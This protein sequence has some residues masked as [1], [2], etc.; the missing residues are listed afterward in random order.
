[1]RYDDRDKEPKDSLK[2]VL[3]SGVC[4][5]QRQNWLIF[6]S[7]AWGQRSTNKRT[8]SGSWRAV[9]Q[10]HFENYRKLTGFELSQ[11]ESAER[12]SVLLLTVSLLSLSVRCRLPMKVG[13]CRAA[14][15]RFF[16][17]VT[18]GNCSGFVYGGCEANRNHFES[19]EECEATCSG[20]TGKLPVYV[21]LKEQCLFKYTGNI[22]SSLTVWGWGAQADFTCRLKKKKKTTHASVIKTQIHGTRY[23]SDMKPL[24]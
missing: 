3:C 8:P 11:S 10:E 4:Y 5:E 2:L 21:C 1:M 12:L 7:E 6:A 13:P 17:N 23:R 22:N 9:A 18:S 16:Y 24:L 20:V 15:P 14:F 19:Q